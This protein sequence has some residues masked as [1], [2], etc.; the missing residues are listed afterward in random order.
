MI[1]LVA[2]FV[3]NE[4]FSLRDSIFTSHTRVKLRYSNHVLKQHNAA[5]IYTGSFPGIVSEMS[6]LEKEGLEIL[7]LIVYKM[8]IF[9]ERGLTWIFALNMRCHKDSK[10]LLTVSKRRDGHAPLQTIVLNTRRSGVDP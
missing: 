10:R 9:L 1:G 2:Y 3:C 8:R 6:G 7:T 5:C 4:E